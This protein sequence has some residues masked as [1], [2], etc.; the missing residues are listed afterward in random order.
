MREHANFFL[1][2]EKLAFKWASPILSLDEMP[3]YELP[4]WVMIASP[5]SFVC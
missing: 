1:V 4:A 2:E 3:R 5:A